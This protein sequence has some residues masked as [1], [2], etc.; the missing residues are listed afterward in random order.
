[1]NTV[2]SGAT[3]TP[4]GAQNFAQVPVPSTDPEIARGK[5]ATV[6]TVQFELLPDVIGGEGG[7]EGAT[8]AALKVLNGQTSS[9][10]HDGAAEVVYIKVVGEVAVNAWTPGMMERTRSVEVSSTPKLEAEKSTVLPSGAPARKPTEDNEA[11]AA[12]PSKTVVEPHF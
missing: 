10:M 9:L 5:P 6:V 8:D 4:D 1:M 2:P 7:G 12:T 11:I 3:S